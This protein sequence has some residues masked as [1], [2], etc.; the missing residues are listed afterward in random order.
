MHFEITAKTTHGGFM[1][2]RL[3]IIALLA[4]V[5]SGCAAGNKQQQAD[6]NS[7]MNS[8]V[9]SLQNQLEAKNREIA[10]LQDQ[11]RALKGQLNG[12][13]TQLELA[14][15]AKGEAESRL[16]QA[17]DKLAQKTGSKSTTPS[18]T[19]VKASDNYVK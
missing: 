7:A 6:V 5:I 12:C 9:A 11:F 18:G 1:F 10:E 4:L 14:S 15:R 13:G 17:L 3:S 2:K 8:K 16:Y 19:V